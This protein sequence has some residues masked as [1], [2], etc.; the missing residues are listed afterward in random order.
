MLSFRILQGKTVLSVFRNDFIRVHFPNT[1]NNGSFCKKLMDMKRFIIFLFVSCL[2]FSGCEEIDDDIEKH[3]SDNAG[4][5]SLYDVAV[6]LSEVELGREHLTEVH[7]AV[8]S[9]SGNGYD[10]EYMMRDLFSCPGAGVGDPEISKSAKDYPNPLRLLIENHL[11]SKET[12]RSSGIFMSAEEYISVLESSDIQIYWPFSENW[13]GKEY[14]VITFDPED[15]SETNVGY[16]MTA[17]AETGERKVEEIVVD[18]ALATEIPVWVVNRN[19]D[20]GYTSLELLR[21]DDPDWGTGGGSVIVKPGSHSA[22]PA[23]DRDESLKTLILKDFT[24]KRNFDS[25]FAG[26]SEFFVKTG[27]VEDFSASTEAELKLY[28]PS[29]TDFM[30]VVKRSQVGKPQPFNAVLV[31]DWSSQLT[32]AAFMIT[33]DDGG[34]R[35]SWKCSAIV[36]ISS[37]SYGID[38]SL[39]LN[40]KD[41][42]VWRGQL[43][44]RYLEANNNIAGHFGDVDLTFEIIEYPR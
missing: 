26:A 22:S 36:K 19:D 34:T 31:S 40:T 15:K 8:T 9:S 30:I 13:D 11:K 16:R 35:T 38:I 24:M 29:I 5:V 4:S 14:P 1:D 10:E 28:S 17:D 3:C 32:H 25:W 42:I 43:S 41:D 33:E 39:P 37:K 6:L 27:G 23:E 2:C 7:D 18:E 12:T 20:S 21:R 44:S